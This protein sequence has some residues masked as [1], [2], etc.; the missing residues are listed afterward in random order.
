MFRDKITFKVKGGRGGD[1]VAVFDKFGKPNGGNG[2]R[3]GDVIFEGSEHEYD[4]SRLKKAQTYSAED[5][6]AG[7]ATNQYGKNGEDRIVKVPLKTMIY[8]VETDEFIT[9][10]SESNQQV[11]I[12]KGGRNGLGNYVFRRGGLQARYSRTIG[13]DGDHLNI[14]LVLELQADVIFIGYPN[15]GKSSILREITNADAKVAAYA[16]TTIDPQ[17]GD[18]DGIRLMDLPGLIEDT[19]EGKG[20][21]TRFVKH[22]KSSKVMAHFLSLES[23][24]IVKDYKTMRKELEAINPVLLEKEEIIILTKSDTIDP[25]ELKKIITK[26]KKLN[27]NYIVTSAFD[28]ESLEELKTKFKSLIK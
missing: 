2:G 16:F 27:P 13:G 14:R 19:H 20:L 11:I 23:E 5:G 26:V 25:K 28:W 6:V 1:G 10:V 12:A 4:L 18:L 24:D 17:I 22:T 21:G 15:A 8:N 7:K 3:G 9:E